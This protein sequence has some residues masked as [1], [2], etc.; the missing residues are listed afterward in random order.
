M[1]AGL[2]AGVHGKNLLNKGAGCKQQS[3]VCYTQCT[4]SM[5]VHF[6]WM[7]THSASSANREKK[8][9]SGTDFSSTFW[10]VFSL[11]LLVLFRALLLK[12]PR[13]PD[14][15]LN[16]P[17]WLNRDRER[18]AEFFFSNLEIYPLWIWHALLIYGMFATFTL[19]DMGVK[20]IT[21]VKIAGTDTNWY[22][23][24]LTFLIHDSCS[25]SLQ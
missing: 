10:S 17:E 3:Q 5:V 11:L 15:H 25:K 1:T 24:T 4:K 8:T 7:Q 20:S 22:T 2:S 13:C 6:S 14:L 12:E 16:P 23:Q 21:I 9:N 19:E 18:E